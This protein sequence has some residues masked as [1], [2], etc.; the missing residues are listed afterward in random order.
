MIVSVGFW[1][2]PLRRM[3]ERPLRNPTAK[4][5]HMH[6]RDRRMVQLLI[7]SFFFLSIRFGQDFF[8]FLDPSSYPPPTTTAALFN[9]QLAA[10]Y[11][12]VRLVG[13]N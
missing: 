2:V 7:I 12:S 1:G 11:F 4:A 8:S 3:K 6:G 5:N 9:L 10:D 13:R